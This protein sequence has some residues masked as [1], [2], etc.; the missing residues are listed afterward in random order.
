MDQPL[1]QWLTGKKIGEFKYLKNEKNFL[2]E[3]KNV[4]HNFWRVIIWWKIKIW[5]KIAQALIL[6]NDPKQPL[7][8][9]NSIKNR[10]FWKRI[11]KKP[12][13]SWLFL[14]NLVPFNKQ[15]HEKNKRGLEL[16]TSPSSAYKTNS[17]K[18]FY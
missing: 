6:V 12:L 16:V 2:D 18:L 9:R 1:N 11:I 8:V 7:H 13:K 5:Q 17:G 15:D 14:N 3:I 10:I 4:F